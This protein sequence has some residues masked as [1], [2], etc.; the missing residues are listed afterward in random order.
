MSS[1]VK[2]SPSLAVCVHH[3]PFPAMAGEAADSCQLILMKLELFWNIQITLRRVGGSDPP[4][5]AQ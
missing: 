5:L 2:A 1:G 3:G 4:E